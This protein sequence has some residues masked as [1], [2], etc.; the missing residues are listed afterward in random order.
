MRELLKTERFS[1]CLHPDRLREIIE[2]AFIEGFES[3]TNSIDFF[4][5]L[6]FKDYEVQYVN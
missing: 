5:K 4:N 2:N 1:I 6:E 3:N